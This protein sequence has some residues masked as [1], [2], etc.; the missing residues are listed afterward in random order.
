M[1]ATAAAFAVRTA[2]TALLS[3]VARFL[4]TCSTQ[5]TVGAGVSV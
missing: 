3:A 1:S 5:P 2:A 4:S